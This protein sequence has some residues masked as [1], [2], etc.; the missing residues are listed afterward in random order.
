[1]N[2]NRKK[3]E[4][5]KIIH[6]QFGEITAPLII[7]ASRATDIPAFYSDWLINR[8]EQRYVAKIN[9]YDRSK[10]SYFSL[11]KVKAIVF[12]S[13]NPDPLMENLSYFNTRK[14]AYY[15]QFTLNDYEKENLEPGLPKLN[16][17][18]ETFKR[19]SEKIGKEKVI[20]RFDPLIK[21]DI[22]SFDDLIERIMK[23]ADKIVTF[24]DKLVFS[25]VEIEL[26]RKVK[27]AFSSRKDIFS[28]TPEK[29]QATLEE[30][31]DVAKKLSSIIPELK[32]LNPDFQIASCADSIDYSIYGIMPNRC[33]DDELLLKISDDAELHQFLRPSLFRDEYYL[34]DRGQR[35]NCGCIL[36][37]D[38]G[39]YDSCPH[40]C[41]YC[42]A[43][44]SREAVLNKIKPFNKMSEYI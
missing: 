6:P 9:P 36:S 31:I 25:F 18:I 15:F 21:T 27:R 3:A 26:Y 16:K 4:F 30:K 41:L 34:K 40:F 13:K 8:F 1:M 43:N 7:S 37:C 42:Y 10:I 24:T 5:P 32:K 29:Y 20:W 14:I 22:T 23:I 11:E 39:A 28:L 35:K 44:S 19:L 17:R 12:W 38:I 33:I 2:N